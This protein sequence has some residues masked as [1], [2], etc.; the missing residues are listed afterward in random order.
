MKPIVLEFNRERLFHLRGGAAD[1]HNIQSPFWQQIA[2]RKINYFDE[3]LLYKNGEG[4]RTRRDNGST[5]RGGATAATVMELRRCIRCVQDASSLCDKERDSRQDRSLR[6]RKTQAMN[7]SN[8]M[9]LSFT[10][11]DQPVDGLG[12]RHITGGD[13]RKQQPMRKST[14]RSHAIW[15]ALILFVVFYLPRR[16]T[17][18]FGCDF[19]AA[20]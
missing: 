5:G 10:R 3:R 2:N 15:N 8:Y 17:P 11:Q 14:S 20:H 16:A 4:R 7:Q 18:R 6:M 9:F 1:D 13:I 19:N 12:H